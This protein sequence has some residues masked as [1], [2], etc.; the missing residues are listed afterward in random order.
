MLRPVVERFL[1]AEGDLN[2]AIHELI[3]GHRQS[4]F[5]VWDAVNLL[6][7]ELSRSASRRRG[8]PRSPSPEGRATSA[9][10]NRQ[11]QKVFG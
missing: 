11:P 10:G 6:T 9:L 7:G 2:A 4:L 8:I 1:K 5:E 3:V